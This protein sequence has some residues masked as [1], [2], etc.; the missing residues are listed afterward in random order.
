MFALTLDSNEIDNAIRKH[1]STFIKG[2]DDMRIEVSFVAGRGPNGSR[3]SVEIYTQEEYENLPS[4]EHAVEAVQ[5]EEIIPEPVK[6]E[7]K[8]EE[9]KEETPEPKKEVKEARPAKVKEEPVKE[10]ATPEA[11]APTEVRNPFADALV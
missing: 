9:V 1:L 6:E 10:E 4:Q 11:P 8:K 7:P 3:A 2:I 5:K